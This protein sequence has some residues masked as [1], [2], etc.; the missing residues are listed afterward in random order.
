M[1]CILIAYFAI[2]VLS[3]GCDVM[4]IINEKVWTNKSYAPMDAVLKL[5]PNDVPGVKLKHEIVHKNSRLGRVFNLLCLLHGHKITYVI[6]R[7]LKH[8]L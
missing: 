7:I 2:P 5:L 8:L 4:H 6:I 3:L 1:M